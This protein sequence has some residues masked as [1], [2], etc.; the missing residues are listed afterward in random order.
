MSDYIGA[1]IMVVIILF[2][3]GEIGYYKPRHKDTAPK[4]A[5]VETD[6]LERIKTAYGVL[7]LSG[8]W[9]YSHDSDGKRH[10]FI[11]YV[12][13]DNQPLEIEMEWNGKTYDPKG[14]T[15]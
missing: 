7:P 3:L 10:D 11:A 5:P 6:M 2:W 12:T 13:S 15:G 9:T 14:W 8:S 1:I 4:S